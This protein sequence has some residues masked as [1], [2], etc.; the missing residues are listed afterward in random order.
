M[1]PPSKPDRRQFLDSK[2]LRYLGIETKQTDS[3]DFSSRHA[4]FA[5]AAGM[6]YAGRAIAEGVVERGVATMSGIALHGVTGADQRAGGEEFP[7]AKEIAGAVDDVVVVELFPGVGGGVSK[8]AGNGNGRL[9]GS[10]GQS[11]SCGQALDARRGKQM[12]IRPNPC[13]FMR[14]FYRIVAKRGCGD[15]WRMKKC[16]V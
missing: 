3:Q 2:V 11:A 10:R 7:A 5:V 9:A 6:E 1:K 14:K 12:W 16:P 15:G 8:G 13:P 4:F